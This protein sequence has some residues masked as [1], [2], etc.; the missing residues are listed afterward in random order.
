VVQAVHCRRS[1][2]PADLA[3]R[4]VDVSDPDSPVSRKYI[5]DYTLPH[6]KVFGRDGVLLW[7]RSAAPLVLT[8]DV[9][10]AITAPRIRGRVK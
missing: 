6:L 2:H 5:G 8:G 9:E 3:V 4:K 7:E 1:R 10:K